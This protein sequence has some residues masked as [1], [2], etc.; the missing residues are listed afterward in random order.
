M[1]LGQTSKTYHSKINPTG[2]GNGVSS[3]GC[4]PSV[5]ATGAMNLV[6]TWV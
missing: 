1:F 3:S 6:M 4:L 5:L 2:E